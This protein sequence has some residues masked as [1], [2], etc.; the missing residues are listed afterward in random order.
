MYYF[1]RPLV[2][3]ACAI[4]AGF[5]ALLLSLGLAAP[6][7]AGPL[8]DAVAAYGRGDHATA[9]RLLGPLAN[10]GSASAEA[11]LGTIYA[12]GQGVPKDYAAALTWYR[13]AAEHGD[14]KAQNNLG[15]MYAQGAAARIAN[16]TKI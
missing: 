13:K 14:A 1:Q 11:M 5:V 16:G 15:F 9:I 12:L 10:R 2:L 6:G 7:A 3:L 8:E 4:M